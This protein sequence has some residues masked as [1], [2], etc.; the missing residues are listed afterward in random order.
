MNL[1][2][3]E[4]ELRP[5][6]SSPQFLSQLCRWSLLMLMD[7]QMQ[8]FSFSLQRLFLVCFE[9]LSMHHPPT[10]DG[11][12]LGLIKALTSHEPN[13]IRLA[14]SAQ[15]LLLETLPVISRI[16]GINHL[17]QNHR[18]RI[19][20]L[21]LNQSLNPLTPLTQLMLNTTDCV[22]HTVLGFFKAEATHPLKIT[23][24]TEY[25]HLNLQLSFLH[26]ILNPLFFT[27]KLLPILDNLCLLLK[28]MHAQIADG[29]N[30]KMERSE[31]KDRLQQLYLLLLYYN[32]KVVGTKPEPR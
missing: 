20:L 19:A 8:V 21:F 5:N 23:P 24:K 31:A 4:L 28:N 2:L 3:L 18:A 6:A 22:L 27:P 9:V 30:S 17:L 7:K 13:H 15:A 26:F 10:V 11:L 12:L 14:L 16:S 25:L 1:V 32:Q 29:G